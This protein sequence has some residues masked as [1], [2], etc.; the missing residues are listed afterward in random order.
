MKLHILSDLHLEFAEFEPDFETADAADVIV[1]AG[2]IHQGA[3]GMKWAR[4][5]F[6]KKTI[7]YVSGNHEFYGYHWDDLLEELRIHA[8]IHGIHFLE[9]DCV[10]IAGIRF[11]GTTLWTDFK[12]FGELHRA[13][14]MRLSETFLNDFQLIQAGPPPLEQSDLYTP[15]ERLAVTQRGNRPYVARLTAAHT[16]LRHEESFA[17]LS[18]ELAT[19][20]PEKTVVVSHH[21]P[22]KNSCAPKWSEDPLSSIFG[23]RLPNEVLLRAKLWVHGHTHDSCDYRIGDSKR[24]VRVICNPRGYPLGWMKH[25][26]ENEQFDPKLLVEI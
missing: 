11:L 26:H 8:E 17:W 22:H 6:P 23:S 15:E 4:D 5:N 7:I 2:D 25:E 21:Y 20:D 13:K 10:T 3:N 24:S 1:L 16:L 19:G 14:N 12:F 18:A 9:N